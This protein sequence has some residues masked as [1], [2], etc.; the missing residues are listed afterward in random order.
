V[1]TGVQTC[2]LPISSGLV[3]TLG[4]AIVLWG[5][6][7]QSTVTLSS[8]EAEYI[9]LSNCAQEAK[10][11]QMLISELG[12][13]TVRPGIIYED[14]MGA[15]Y[16]SKNDHVSARTK[17]I[18]IRHHFLRELQDQGD[19]EVVKIDTSENPAD[20]ST[21]NTRESTHTKHA[22]RIRMGHLPVHDREDVKHSVF[23]SDVVSH[24]CRDTGGD[25]GVRGRAADD[26]GAQERVIENYDGGWIEVTARSRTRTRPP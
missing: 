1:V 2:A 12:F 10:F 22:E 23:C 15:I 6:K 25:V 3:T 14:N 5:S 11:L 17:H 19:I 21:K 18:D 20:I 8:T 7:K 24:G 13:K 9:A 26:V 4:G 16:L